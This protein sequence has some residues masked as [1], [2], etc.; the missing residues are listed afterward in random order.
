VAWGGASDGMA[1]VWF[2]AGAT[3]FEFADAVTLAIVQS[4]LMGFAESKRYNDFINPG[5]QGEPGSFAGFEAGLGGTGVNGYPGASFDPFGYSK[6]PKVLESMKLKEIKNGACVA[7][8]TAPVVHPPPS[9]SRALVRPSRRLG[10]ESR[11]TEF[12]R[13]PSK[14][15]ATCRATA[16]RDWRP[17]E[18]M[19]S[20]H[21][22]ES[23]GRW[24]VMCTRAT[25]RR[26]TERQGILTLKA[27]DLPWSPT[28][29]TG[30]QVAWL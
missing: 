12:A 16:L 23:S 2:E 9:R 5:S 22:I 15:V 27:T 17:S 30:A 24:Q 29:T 18:G 14:H 26:V 6:D 28:R 19:P 1:Q 11:R 8:S 13:T 25:H 7:A 3:K 10:S 21:R 20:D 4:F